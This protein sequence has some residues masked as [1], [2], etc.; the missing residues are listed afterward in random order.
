ML[1]VVV[2]LTLINFEMLS[3]YAFLEP[4][5]LLMQL[6]D[7]PSSV[8]LEPLLLLNKSLDISDSDDFV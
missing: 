4:K 6:D 2:F 1:A 8:D 5:A 7:V 3:S